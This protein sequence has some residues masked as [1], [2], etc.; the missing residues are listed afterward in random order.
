VTSAVAQ[1]F[2]NPGSHALLQNYPNPF[3]PATTIR[4]QVPAA[5]QI[6][7]T[8]LNAL[9]QKVRTLL[10]RRLEAGQHQVVWDS[11]DDIGEKV[12]SG[13]YFVRM[14]AAKGSA[15]SEFAQTRKLA[16]VQ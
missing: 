5:S 13:V 7:L 11:R 15:S 4:F 3:N 14:R 9:G 12:A 1:E 16:L 2:S 10:D 6:T 8:I